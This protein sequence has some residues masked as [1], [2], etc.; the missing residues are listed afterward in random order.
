MGVIPTAVSWLFKAIK[1]ILLRVCERRRANQFE[2]W[3]ESL[4]LRELIE[5]EDG[6]PWFPL[7]LETATKGKLALNY[8]V[9]TKLE[10]IV[11]AEAI[12]LG[13]R[14]GENWEVEAMAI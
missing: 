12:S 3:K 2:R 5:G 10:C 9:H 8:S 14:L 13:T 4:A 7:L 6:Y 11:D 1:S